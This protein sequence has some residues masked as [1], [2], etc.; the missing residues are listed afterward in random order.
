MLESIYDLE[1]F[2]GIDKSVVEEIILSSPEKEFK[3]WEV[4]LSEWEISNGE[5]YI[6]KSWKVKVTIKWEEVAELFSGNMFWEIALLN[7]EERT[8]SVEA[9]E[10]TKTIV[11]SLDNLINL[12]N[13]DSNKINKEIIRRIEENLE[14]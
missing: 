8:A 1:I 5:W 3:S 10:D 7:E 14:R 9:V 11:L 2:K 12:I 4:I 6:I 13:N